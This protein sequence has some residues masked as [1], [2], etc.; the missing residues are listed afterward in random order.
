MAILMG[1][2][3]FFATASMEFVRE[4]I[5]KPYLI[6][7]VM[8]SSGILVSN[9][10]RLNQDG[11]L[12]HSDWVLPDSSVHGNVAVG[13]ALYK[14]E[15]MRCH[16]VDGYNAMRALV[17][18]WSDSLVIHALNHLDELKR[19]MPPFIG[20]EAEK[21]ALAEYLGTLTGTVNYDPPPPPDSTATR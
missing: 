10:E 6:Y 1:L 14:L 13:A 18:G 17:H 3:A 2:I 5:R 20:T 7:G 12:P 11:V 19:F 21:R 8:Y 15:C 16:Q 9:T 4:G